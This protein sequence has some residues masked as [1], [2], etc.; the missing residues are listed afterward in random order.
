MTGTH[1]PP[2]ASGGEP[3]PRGSRQCTPRRSPRIVAFITEPKVI[4]RI[5]DHFRRDLI[6]GQPLRVDLPRHEDQHRRL[7]GDPVLAGTS[8]EAEG[9][10]Q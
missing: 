4:D 3:A 9:A 2:A 8:L 6:A 10:S 7:A 5:L 1:H